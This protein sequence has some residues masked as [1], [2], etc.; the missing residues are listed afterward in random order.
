MILEELHNQGRTHAAVDLDGTLIDTGKTFSLAIAEASRYLE[1]DRSI[2]DECIKGTRHEFSVNPAIVRVAV[3]IAARTLGLPDTDSQVVAALERID[4]IYTTD[5]PETFPGA[6][7]VVQALNTSFITVLTTHAER[8][9]TNHKKRTAGLT[10]LFAQTHC[11]P[12][13]IPKSKYWQ[14]FFTASSIP[15][16]QWLV[17]GDDLQADLAVPARLGAFTIHVQNGE[18]KQFSPETASHRIQPS[19][20]VAHIADLLTL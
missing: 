8:D 10:G 20:T 19:L 7:A 11:F 1:T 6:I 17:I 15:P 3:L 16:E 9:Y 13:Q 2:I 12:V 5:V 18:T 4:R 14:E